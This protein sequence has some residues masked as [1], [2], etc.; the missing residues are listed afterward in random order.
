[1]VEYNERRDGDGCAKPD[2]QTGSGNYMF[3]VVLSLYVTCVRDIYCMFGKLGI[4]LRVF[5][6]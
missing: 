6:V 5:V 4:R 1:M 3:H 2:S